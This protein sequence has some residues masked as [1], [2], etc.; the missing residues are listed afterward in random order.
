MTTTPSPT[1]RAALAAGLGSFALL[2]A[3]CGE[4]GLFFAA[5]SAAG[6]V[7]GGLTM[8]SS[9]TVKI[10]GPRLAAAK[11]AAAQAAVA[12][13]LADV[14]GR[15]SHYDANSE[16]S[17]LN[18]H[19]VGVPFALTAATLHVFDV[20]QA[21]HM[22]SDGAFDV[23]LGRAVDEWGFGPSERPRRVLTAQSVQA[24]QREPGE[25]ALALDVG[26]GTL[27]RRAPVLTNLS[28]IAKGFGVDQA[29]QALDRLD[30]GDYLIEVG[31]E[32]RARGRNAEDRPWQ[33]AVELPDAM[34]Q[35]ALFIVPLAGK[36]LATSGDYRNFF[37]HQGR[38]YSHEIDPASAAPVDHS[39]ASV[40][41]VADDCTHADAWSTA[42]FVLGPERG[43]E[44]ATRHQL[45]AYF[46]E[47]Q[48][49]GSFRARQTAAFAALG[50]HAAA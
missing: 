13:A 22:A 11:L 46:V 33:L 6:P 39:L 3:G 30:I 2:A 27:T 10:A 47:R 16:V 31:G 48:G 29:A 19:R 20:A 7:F 24:L 44:V 8:G 37:L 21:V 23:A 18:R 38:R 14:V 35:R 50:G 15:M 17:R 28:G 41:V 4:R 26:A 40:S 5:P 34:P 45:A 43:F 25:D 36:A 42:L 12:E 32:I 9:Y 49:D 1:R